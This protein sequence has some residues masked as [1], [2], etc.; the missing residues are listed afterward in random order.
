MT[1]KKKNT[2][3]SIIIIAAFIIVIVSVFVSAAAKS[4]PASTDADRIGFI[5]TLGLTCRTEPLSVRNVVIPAEF[6]EVYA[7]YNELQTAAG[8]DLSPY[9]GEDAIVYTYSV[10]DYPS[11]D[12]GFY[13]DIRANIIVIGEKI[14]G[15][16]ISSA[17][18]DGFMTGLCPPNR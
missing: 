16:D 8:F 7:A 2:V 14:V 4:I 18:L 15:G 1:T 9:K 5:K 13:S 11:P 17:A 10:T 6:G 12:G 3:L